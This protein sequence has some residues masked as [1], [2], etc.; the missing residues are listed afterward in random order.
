[1]LRLNRRTWIQLSILTLVT[2]THQVQVGEGSLRQQFSVEI[3]DGIVTEK[4][5]GIQ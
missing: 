2:G 5:V 4:T 1:M 3:R